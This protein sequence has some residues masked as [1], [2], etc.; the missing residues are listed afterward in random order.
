MTEPLPCPFCGH[1]GLSHHEGTTFRWLTTECNG[2]GAQC[3]EERIDTLST[4]QGAAIEK[5]AEAAIKAWNTRAALEQQAEPP[6]E[7]LLIKNI[8][9]EYGLD[10]IAFVAEW[11]AAQR[12][13]QG[14][15][16]EQIWQMANDCLDSVTGAV[17]FARAIEDKLKEKNDH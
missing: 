9:A 7:W 10:A 6:P 1:V 12:Q 2:C 8:L 11:K 17:K 16:D 3:A 4:D 13:W 5:A 14:L 15:T